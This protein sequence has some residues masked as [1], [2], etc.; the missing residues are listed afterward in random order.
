MT[1][2]WVVGLVNFTAPQLIIDCNAAAVLLLGSNDRHVRVIYCKANTIYQG[3]FKNT[4]A[5]L[6]D[7][8]EG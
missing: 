4:C 2:F 8:V 3:D 6:H 5:V 1:L 7:V